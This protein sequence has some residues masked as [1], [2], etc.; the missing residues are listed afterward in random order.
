MKRKVLI[1]RIMPYSTMLNRAHMFRA[2]GWEPYLLYEQPFANSKLLRDCARTF[3]EIW[4]QDIIVESANS[5]HDF[6]RTRGFDLVYTIGPPDRSNVHMANIPCPWIHDM[7]D[8]FLL[9]TPKADDPEVAKKMHKEFANEEARSAT[10]INACDMVVYVT[11]WQRERANAKLYPS[12]NHKASVWLPNVPLRI[13]EINKRDTVG[14]VRWGYVGNMKAAWQDAPTH[15]GHIAAEMDRLGVNHEFHVWSFMEM[16]ESQPM[17]WFFSHNSLAQEDLIKEFGETVDYGILFPPTASDGSNGKT[18]WPGKVGDYIAS[19]ATAL[20]PSDFMIRH[21]LRRKGWGISYDTPKDAARIIASG[22]KPT[23][24]REPAPYLLMPEMMTVLKGAVDYAI[25]A[26]KKREVKLTS[27]PVKDVVLDIVVASDGNA[28]H[29]REHIAP[30]LGTKFAMAGDK[31]DGNPDLYLLGM[32]ARDEDA[33][34]KHLEF[35]E[36]FNRIIVQWAGTDSLVAMEH[37]KEA[38]FRKIL[39]HPRVVH[40]APDRG[41]ANNVNRLFVDDDPCKIVHCPTRRI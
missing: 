7:R 9:T 25:D 26:Y 36:Q 11:P 18:G 27:I 2:M 30:I 21:P 34:N 6:I 5:F 24:P 32:W 8:L 29:A 16:Q 19:G 28:Y 15:A 33:S 41:I 14:P 20:V 35:F 17:E 13:P 1:C 22:R 37:A 10:C 31:V 4:S 3:E 40:V 23:S 39:Y 12:G 38:W